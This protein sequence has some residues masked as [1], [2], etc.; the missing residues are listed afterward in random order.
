MLNLHAHSILKQA[1]FLVV[2]AF[3]VNWS[4]FVGGFGYVFVA[5]EISTGKEFALKVSFV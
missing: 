4:F 1:I 2:D 5:Q 3:E